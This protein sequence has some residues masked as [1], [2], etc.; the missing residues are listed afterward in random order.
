MSE[1]SKLRRIVLPFGIAAAGIGTAAAVILRGCWHTNMSWPLSHNGYSYRTCTQC[2][3]KRL[4]DEQRFR[5]YGPYGYDVE[6]LITKAE[7]A[8]RPQKAAS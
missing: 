1:K 2:G 7:A 4:F 3:I 6:E 5:S 8:K